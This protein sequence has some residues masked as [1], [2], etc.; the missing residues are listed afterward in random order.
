LRRWVVVDTNV[1]VSGVF[2]GH[3]GSPTQKIVDEM[4]AGAVRF[5]VSEA[6]V[7]EYR[8]VLLRPRIAA[9]HRLSD[10]EVDELLEMML[11]NAG[12]REVAASRVA[13]GSVDQGEHAARG[14]EH[15]VALLKAQSGA[16]LITGDRRLAEAVSGWC[17]VLTP[18]EFAAT[19][20]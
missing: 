2:D 20:D 19:L 7:F 18:A 12:I 3:S 1:V 8:R 14:D 4:L 13:E 5:L 11:L 17:Q 6:L 15:I 9:R 16:T 10:A